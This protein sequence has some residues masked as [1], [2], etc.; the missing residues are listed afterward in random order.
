MRIIAVDDEELAVDNIMTLLKEVEPDAE[1]V[2][3]T[4]PEEAFDYLSQNKIEIAFLDIEMGEYSGL[5]LADKCRELCPTVNIIFVTGYSK[6]SLD[7]YKLR[8]SGYLMKPIR[9]DDLRVEMDNLRHPLSEKPPCRVRIHTFGNFEVFVDEMPLKLPRTKCKECLAY[10]VDRK[11]AGVTYAQLSSVIWEGKP[12]GLSQ[13]NNTYKVVSE[14]MKALKAV[15][16]ADII[17]KNHTD[18][19]VDTA[20][21]D[22][23]YYSATNGEIAGIS[24]FTGE[25][26]TNYSW[27][28]FT[29]GELIKLKRHTK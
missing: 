22:C 8:V 29:L 16:A 2:G 10:L 7:A 19:A 15:D 3:F 11:G 25:Y 1:L 23:D 28:E 6:Y 4:E 20:K 5:A 17:L 24:A 13:Q 14:L 12:V 27:A 9:M 26:M 18:I 21:L